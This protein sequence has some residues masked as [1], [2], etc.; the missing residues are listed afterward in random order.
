MTPLSDA[1]IVP[2]VHLNGTP[3]QQLVDGFLKALDAL[4]DA[5]IRLA[6][7]APLHRDFH[8]APHGGVRFQE[9]VR[10]HAMRIRA[11]RDLQEEIETLALKV[12]DR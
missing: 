11:L 4:R 2:I 8:V 6:A 5:E 9:A 12:H 7:T 3:K 10:Q 1:L